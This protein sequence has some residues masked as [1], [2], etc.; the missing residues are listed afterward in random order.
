MDLVSAV[1]FYLVLVQFF[2]SSFLIIFSVAQLNSHEY[3]WILPGGSK[4]VCFS[5]L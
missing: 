3:F 4:L 5:R 2:A 1:P